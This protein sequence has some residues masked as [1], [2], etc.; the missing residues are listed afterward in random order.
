[1]GVS[2]QQPADRIPADQGGAITADSRPDGG[3]VGARHRPI[4]PVLVVVTL[5]LGLAVRAIG[6]PLEMVQLAAFSALALIAA[7]CPDHTGRVAPRSVVLPAVLIGALGALNV[8]GHLPTIVGDAEVVLAPL[9]DDKDRIAA[10]M[11]ERG[12]DVVRRTYD[13]PELKKVRTPVPDASAANVIFETNPATRLIISGT[14]SWLRAYITPQAGSLFFRESAQ[15]TERDTEGQ[16]YGFIVPRDGVVV[17]AGPAEPGLYFVIAPEHV[18]VPGDPSELAQHLLGWISSAL[19]GEI[20]DGTDPEERARDFAVRN[21]AL[22][23]AREV[24]GRWR[25][26]MPTI[27]ADLLRASLLVA[28]GARPGERN[29]AALV[30]AARLLGSARRWVREKY[31][32]EL[33][34]AVLNDSAVLVFLIDNDR[35]DRAEA[36]R[37]L[38]NAAQ[39]KGSDGHPVR[40]ARA[41]IANI[42]TLES[43]GLLG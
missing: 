42:A 18:T 10:R 39:T 27:T 37:W 6:A 19:S 38:W 28:E 30:E 26:A 12:F 8:R 3:A 1:M 5:V 11:F 7:V 33:Y 4:L 20:P 32:P 36:M 21:A 15:P 23:E 24:R 2:V 16:R 14:A 40:G 22:F 43:S 9:R 31:E 25:S 29:L 41:A 13:L 34:A 17:R 35:G